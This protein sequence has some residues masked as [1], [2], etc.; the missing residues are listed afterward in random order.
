MAV[1]DNESWYTVSERIAAAFG[2]LRSSVF[3]LYPV[4]G[5]IQKIGRGD[6]ACSFDWIAGNQYWWE[7]ICDLGLDL[8]TGKGREIK[9]IDGLGRLD[10]L[11]VRRGMTVSWRKICGFPEKLP[12]TMPQHN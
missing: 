6:F 9:I 1:E 12:I 3:R 11:V 5:E 7:N 2:M 4:D 10:T 8:R